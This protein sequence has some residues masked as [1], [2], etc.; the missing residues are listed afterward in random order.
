[1]DFFNNTTPTTIPFNLSGLDAPLVRK[2][3]H[4]EVDDFIIND[5]ML[6]IPPSTISIEKKAFNHEW[7]TLRTRSSQK[8]KSGHSVARMFLLL[9]S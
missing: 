3:G 2:V 9:T 5:V 6:R 4:L 7:Q 1:L 8:A